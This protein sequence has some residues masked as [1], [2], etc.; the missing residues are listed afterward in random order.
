[1]SEFIGFVPD[2]CECCT[3]T[4]NYILAVDRGITEIVKAFAKAISIKG[5][6]VIHPIK[7][8]ANA[9]LLTVNQAKNLSRVG[10]HDLIKKVEHGN[11]GITE[12]GIAYLKGLEIPK[13]VIV[14]K[15]TGE[16]TG[17]Y[18]P[19]TYKV[20]AISFKEKDEYWEIYDFIVFE[21]RVIKNPN[22]VL[23]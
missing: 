4:K 23:F 20:K 1:M 3:Q 11:W 18:E 13:Y 2:R 5:I 19:D 15:V 21:G 22:K 6:N 7:E 14:S 12:K 17:Y 16:T 8:M 9:R 10:F